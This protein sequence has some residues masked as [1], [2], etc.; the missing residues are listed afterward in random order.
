LKVLL[1]ESTIKQKKIFKLKENQEDIFNL[2]IDQWIEN[3]IKAKIYL[4]LGE[5]YV[6]EKG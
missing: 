6:I 3:A 5:H 4:K 2:L 1:K